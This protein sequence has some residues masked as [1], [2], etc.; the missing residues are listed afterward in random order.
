MEKENDLSI[1]RQLVI[2]QVNS[3]KEPCNINCRKRSRA[4]NGEKQG[5]EELIGE[6]LLLLDKDSL[7]KW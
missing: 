2:F 4:L 1:S 5:L 6:I 7:I 3:C